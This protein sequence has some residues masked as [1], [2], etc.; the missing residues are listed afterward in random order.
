LI[1]PTQAEARL[2]RFAS[3]S[4]DGYPAVDWQN[5]ARDHAR[6]VAGE[7]KRHVSDIVGLDQAEQVR[8]GKL[9]QRGVS[10]N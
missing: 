8:V 4:R 7:I 2:I 9:R 10:C 3:S 6:F 5:L 1:L